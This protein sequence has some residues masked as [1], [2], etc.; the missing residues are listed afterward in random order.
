MYTMRVVVVVVFLC[1]RLHVEYCVLIVYI[2]L[3]FKLLGGN[4]LEGIWT[5]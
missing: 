2:Y 3:S 1:V 5:R 4:G